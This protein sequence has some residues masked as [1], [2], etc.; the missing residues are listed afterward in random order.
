MELSIIGY[1]SVGAWKETDLSLD[2]VLN[3][4]NKLGITWINMD[5]FDNKEAITKI[6]SSFGIHSLTLEDIMDNQQRPKVEDFEEYLFFTFK[7]INPKVQCLDKT[8]PV[9]EQISLILFHD[10]VLT[11]QE[12][13]GDS[14]D[15]VRK[16]ILNNAGRIRKMGADF[17]VWALIDSIVD[18]YFICLERMGNE[19]DAFEERAPDD[20]DS[21]FIPDL[22]EMKKDLNRIRRIIW[23]LRE[24]LSLLIHLDT[25]L[26]SANLAPFLKDVHDKLVQ[27]C[28]TL[29]SFR[30]L[31]SGMMEVNLSAVSAKM[32]NV[33][34]VL[35]IISTIFIPL[36]FIVGVY[37][38]NFQNMPELVS[39]YGYP[40][41]W[42]VMIIIA[43][44]MLIF[45]KRKRWI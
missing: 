15:G 44:G 37:G 25:E 11:F 38:M 23:P 45:F 24:S 29:D 27:S 28:E 43:I 19:I 12:I 17:L 42:A 14:F 32:N 21:A 41:T 16:R 20:K 22:Q 4:R 33:M 1:D 5:G 7:A 34:K 13:P 8:L 31:I 18:Q 35:T 6:T 40:I 10:T 36:T 3:H 39:P 9:F 2:E 30:E 26:I